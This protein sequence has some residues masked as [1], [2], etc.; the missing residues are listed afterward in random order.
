MYFKEEKND[1]NQLFLKLD[2][3]KDGTLS[4]EELIEG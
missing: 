1:L 2:T 4:K 3:N